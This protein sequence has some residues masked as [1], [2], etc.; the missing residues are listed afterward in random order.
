MFTGSPLDLPFAPLSLS[1]MEIFR[2]E[3]TRVA[4]IEKLLIGVLAGSLA[5]STFSAMLGNWFA[6]TLSTSV[7]LLIFVAFLCYKPLKNRVIFR[8]DL[9]ISLAAVSFQKSDLYRCLGDRFADEGWEYGWRK[10]IAE[11]EACTLTEWVTKR[12]QFMQE[13]KK[14]GRVMQP[15]DVEMLEA[16]RR[17][18]VANE[19]KQKATSELRETLERLGAV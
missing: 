5:T 12:N 6:V 3:A 18:I 14:Q 7:A 19:D 9:P 11:F 2:G 13:L 8:T 17:E 4:N 16:L 1:Q 15:L 10:E